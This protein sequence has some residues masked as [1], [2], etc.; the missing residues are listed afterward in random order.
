ML[1]FVVRFLCVQFRSIVKQN[2]TSTYFYL[3]IT[4][5]RTKISLL[6]SYTWITL[7]FQTDISISNN[8]SLQTTLSSHITIFSPKIHGPN[9]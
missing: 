7:K 8:T 4:T 9:P 2:P 1:P 3:H 6:L 5:V